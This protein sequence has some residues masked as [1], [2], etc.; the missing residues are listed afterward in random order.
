MNGKRRRQ[1][2]E[3]EDLPAGRL[4]GDHQVE[5]VL[6]RMAQ[7]HDGVHQDREEGD[8]R[9][10]QDLG[11][12][13]ETEPDHQERRQGDLRHRLDGNHVGVEHSVDDA[14]QG[15]QRTEDERRDR[16]DGKPEQNFRQRD[17]EMHEHGSR[18]DDGIQGREDARRRRQD[19]LGHA[20]Q[21]HRDFP[22][23]HKAHERARGQNHVATRPACL[24]RGILGAG[25]AL[26]GGVERRVGVE[27]CRHGL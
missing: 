16:A 8:D 13:A 15:D 18:D 21:P 10:H 22:Q 12:E 27:P 9:G 14:E 6:L 23:N 3:P 1:P 24:D 19:D 2:D 26:G 25:A 7:P 11:L 4:Q 17:A 5:P 20:E